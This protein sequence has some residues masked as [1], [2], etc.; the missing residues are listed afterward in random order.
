MSPKLILLAKQEFELLPRFFGSLQ[1]LKMK[2][3]IP[4]DVS[5]K[6]AKGFIQ[7]VQELVLLSGMMRFSLSAHC[8][9]VQAKL[10]QG[11]LHIFPPINIVE[12]CK[13]PR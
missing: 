2:E 6:E 7:S 8:H 11:D 3:E 13:D 1:S 9:P 10:V 4:R 12:G 5:K